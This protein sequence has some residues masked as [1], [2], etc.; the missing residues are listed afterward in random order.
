MITLKPCPFCGAEPKT[1]TYNGGARVQ[2]S[3]WQC[4][5]EPT[6]IV[7]IG[8]KTSDEAATAWNTRATETV[9][10][11]AFAKL[12]TAIENTMEDICGTYDGTTPEHLRP[13]HKA[14]RNHGR[15]QCLD[16]LDRWAAIAERG[17]TEDVK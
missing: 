15:K 4:V 3:N 6:H 12:R 14:E 17:E 2:C 7:S 5:H 13:L 9:H 10:R 8:G 1:W 16:L 11:I